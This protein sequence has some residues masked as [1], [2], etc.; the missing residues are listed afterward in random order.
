[1]SPDDVETLFTRSDGSYAFARWGRPLAPVVFGVDDATLGVVKDALAALAE[2]S[3]A[4]LAETDPELGVNVMMFFVRDWDELRR[5]PDL[6]RLI[7]DLRPLLDRLESAGAN[8]YRIFRFD[9]GGAIRASFGF[10]RMDDEMRAVPARTV[11]LAQAAQTILLW[12]DTAFTD[13]SP[14]AE[15]P[16]G[17]IL[18]RPEIGQL[19]RAA[20]DPVLPAAA[21]DASHALRLAARMGRDTT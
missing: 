3:G 18:L 19:V 4:G 8:Q 9:E 5:V 1:M 16:E 14:L 20:Y 2:L 12:S 15:T 7:P 11:A 17:T 13:R 21:S 10:I 6:D